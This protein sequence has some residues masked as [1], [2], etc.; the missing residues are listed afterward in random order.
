VEAKVREEELYFGGRSGLR[1]KA[2]LAETDAVT[3]RVLC[4]VSMV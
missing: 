1:T 3:A 2:T 4:R